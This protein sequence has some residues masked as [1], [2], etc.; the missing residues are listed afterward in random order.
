MKCPKCGYVEPEEITNI[1][2]GFTTP[3]FSRFTNYE[4]P[5]S[6]DRDE[7]WELIYGPDFEDQMGGDCEELDLDHNMFSW[8]MDDVHE[9]AFEEIKNDLHKLHDNHPNRKIELYGYDNDHNLVETEN[10]N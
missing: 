7:L 6:N 10:I 3:E 9:D 1:E 2:C 4:D 5:T 8:V